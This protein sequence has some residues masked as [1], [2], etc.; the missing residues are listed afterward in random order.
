MKVGFLPLYAT[1]WICHSAQP[2]LLQA[3]RETY[4]N[5]S[6]R[7]QNSG[8]T[9]PSTHPQTPQTTTAT[10]WPGLERLRGGL[11]RRKQRM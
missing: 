8:K 11:C 4:I 10:S 6:S 5:P 3:L 1:Y 9:P 7:I 2:A